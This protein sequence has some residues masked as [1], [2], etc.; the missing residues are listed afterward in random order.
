MKTFKPM[1]K[2]PQ[3]SGFKLAECVSKM[4][5]MENTNASTYTFFF[6]LNRIMEVKDYAITRG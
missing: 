4:D 5:M 3:K 2:R 6:V 1:K